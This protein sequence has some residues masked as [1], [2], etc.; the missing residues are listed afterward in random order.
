MYGGAE[1]DC[2]CSKCGIIVGG[3][4]DNTFKM[5][6]PSLTKE[7]QEIVKKID[8]SWMI[9]HSTEIKDNGKKIELLLGKGES[10]D[11]IIYNPQDLS[12]DRL[13]N[14]LYNDKD[15]TISVD[16]DKF[17]HMC[18]KK[19]LKE[20]YANLKKH[21]RHESIFDGQ[22]F[23]SYRFI[24]KVLGYKKWKEFNMEGPLNEIFKKIEIAKFKELAELL[25]CP[26]KKSPQKIT[27]IYEESKYLSQALLDKYKKDNLTI[28]N[29]KIK[30]ELEANKNVVSKNVVSKN[31]VLFSGFRDSELQAQAEM[32]GWEVKSSFSKAVT[33]LVVKDGSKETEKIK[34]ARENGVKIVTIDDFR[35]LI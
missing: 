11:Y 16:E 35:K 26:I 15:K 13:D 21:S 7:Q 23:W 3:S 12:K 2:I 8:T 29:V 5:L 6:L 27:E 25:T 24:M 30:V 9:D 10:R 22:Y 34:K 20:W 14:M 1:S 31:V 17:T 28:L 4:F 33:L 32:K 18:C 19:D